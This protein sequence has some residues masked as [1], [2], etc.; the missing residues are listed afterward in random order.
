LSK[1]SSTIQLR[2]SDKDQASGADLN[3]IREID[4][5]SEALEELRE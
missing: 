3:K 2:T 5:E 4:E 1:K